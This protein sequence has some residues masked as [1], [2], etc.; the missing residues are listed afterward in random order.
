MPKIVDD[1]GPE[2][3]EEVKK[4]FDVLNKEDKKGGKSG[5]GGKGK[6]TV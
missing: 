3:Y 1:F 6:E 4:W 2:A 5:D